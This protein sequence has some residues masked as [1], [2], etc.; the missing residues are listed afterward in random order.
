MNNKLKTIIAICC[1]LCGGFLS[2]RN[3]MDGHSVLSSDNL[4]AN[5]LAQTASSGGGYDDEGGGSGGGGGGGSAVIGD[6]NYDIGRDK[7]CIY[8][9]GAGASASAII[10]KFPLAKVEANGSVD[11]GDATRIYQ[12]GNICR[13]GTDVTCADVFDKILYFLGN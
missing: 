1:I 13:L 11:L 8:Q 12:T 10:K 4:N 5:V 2:T 6:F 9:V 7:P 3:I